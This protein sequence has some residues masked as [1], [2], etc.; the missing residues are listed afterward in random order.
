[1][2]SLFKLFL[3]LGFSVVYAQSV[4]DYAYVYVPRTFNDFKTENRYNLNKLLTGK[5]EAKNF[6]VIRDDEANWTVDKCDVLVA[7]LADDSNMLRNRVKLHLKDCYGKVLYTEQGVSMIKDFEPGFQDALSR[8]VANVPASTNAGAPLTVKAELPPQNV[9]TTPEVKKEI[10]NVLQS[11]PEKVKEAQVA[12]VEQPAAKEAPAVKATKSENRAETYSN[13]SSVYNKVIL[14]AGHFIFTSSSSSV[15]YATFKESGKKDVYH[16]QL[17]N[18]T[19]TLGYADGNKL[20]V[21][22]PQSDGSYRKE[23]FSRK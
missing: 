23:E 21:E 3:I 10:E 14:G 16:V 2:K 20:V 6:K 4:A 19:K 9:T 17:E 13:G 7:E 18:G 12:K 22:M 5:L 1:M 8:A 15:P 11:K